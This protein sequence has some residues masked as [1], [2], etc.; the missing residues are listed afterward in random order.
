MKCQRFTRNKRQAI[1]TSQVQLKHNEKRTPANEKKKKKA[2]ND[3][4]KLKQYIAS[5][6]PFLSIRIFFLSTCTL[7]N[8][9]I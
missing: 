8:I 5:L 6:S 2:R 9:K 7:W 1:S 3:I 4:F